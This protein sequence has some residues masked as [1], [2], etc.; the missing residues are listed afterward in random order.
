MSNG[1]KLAKDDEKMEYSK[2]DIA[3]GEYTHVY[4]LEKCLN[5]IRIRNQEANEL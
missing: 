5:A 2:Y 4:E 3:S 1:I